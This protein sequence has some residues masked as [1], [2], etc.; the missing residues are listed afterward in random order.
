MHFNGEEIRALAIPGGHTD[1]DVVVFFTK[2]NVVHMGDLFNSG[3]SS[4]P[5]VDF[6]SG[7]NALA[8][9]A[10][11]E[12]LLPLI[13]DDATIIAGHGPISDKP[14][15]FRLR[16][17]L[18]D[19]ITLVR[20]QKEAGRSLAEIIAVGPGPEYESWG[21]GYMSADGWIEMIYRSLGGG[22]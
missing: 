7:G 5:V 9:L 6:G 4:F 20:T 11:I 17:M 3:T 10:N 21:Y 8:I 12:A 22:S 13:P 19:T 2:S 15:L 18:D 16:Q 14:E 1:N